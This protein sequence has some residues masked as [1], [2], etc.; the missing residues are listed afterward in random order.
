M[1][2]TTN[3]VSWLCHKIDRSGCLK[4]QKCVRVCPSRARE[5]IDH[6]KKFRADFSPAASASTNARL[7]W[8][9]L[10]KTFFTP[11]HTKR[12]ETIV[13]PLYYHCETIVMQ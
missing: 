13:Y 9:P 3:P 5:G 1:S 11:K 8:F 10:K 12:L 2:A 7:K 6:G 4:C